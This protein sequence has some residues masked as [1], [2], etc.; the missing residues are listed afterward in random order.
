MKKLIPSKK[1]KKVK[2]V[3]AIDESVEEIVIDDLERRELHY[4]G[5]RKKSDDL[6]AITISGIELSEG[7]ESIEF[8]KGNHKFGTVAVKGVKPDGKCDFTTED[9]DGIVQNVDK[10][11]FYDGLHGSVLAVAERDNIKMQFSDS[12]EPEHIV[13]GKGNI[14]I[15]SSVI[16]VNGKKA[17]ALV[18]A[19]KDDDTT[20]YMDGEEMTPT[21]FRQTVDTSR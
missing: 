17:D 4:F 15:F 9:M 19:V 12:T 8:Y 3:Q 1:A 18:I 2:S 10:V 5:W 6:L 21:K 7:Y 13:D 16:N 14:G 20:F 11:K